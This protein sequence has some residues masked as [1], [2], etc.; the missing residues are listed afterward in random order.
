[1]GAKV[2]YDSVPL[3]ELGARAKTGTSAI[4][5]EMPVGKSYLFTQGSGSFGGIR[6]AMSRLEG[7]FTAK[8]EKTGLRVWRIA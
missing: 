4:L 1:M 6:V 3:P 2:K 7:K 8:P 5:R